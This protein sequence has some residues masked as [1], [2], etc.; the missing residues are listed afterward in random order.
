MIVNSIQTGPFQGSQ[1]LRVGGGTKR[2]MLVLEK[3]G[4]ERN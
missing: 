1:K 2:F 4:L 3:R